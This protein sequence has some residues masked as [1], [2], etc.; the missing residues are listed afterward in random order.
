VLHVKEPIKNQQYSFT[1]GGP[2]C[3]DRLHFFG[4]YEYERQP[5]TA[6]FNTP[7]P[8]FNIRTSGTTPRTRV[9]SASTTRSRRA[10]A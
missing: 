3:G 9:V 2:S 10:P 8:A 1:L 6:I 5:Q 4:N 7:Y